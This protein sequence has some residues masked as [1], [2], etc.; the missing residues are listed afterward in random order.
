VKFFSIDKNLKV[1]VAVIVLI[2]NHSKSTANNKE[3]T[4]EETKEP[5]C[6]VSNH[7]EVVNQIK[8]LTAFTL[9]KGD[10]NDYNMLEPQKLILKK[11]V[12]ITK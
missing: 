12:Q 11:I 9:Q 3:E 5:E 10:V 8:Q 1:E 7:S 2:S 6:N 4:N